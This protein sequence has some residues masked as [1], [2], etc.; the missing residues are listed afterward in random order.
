MKKRISSSAVG[1]SVRNPRWELHPEGGLLRDRLIRFAVWIGIAALCPLAQA[2]NAMPAEF[3][4]IAHRGASG[5]LP[6][7][8]QEAKALAHA[9][10]ADFLEQD[11]V[12]TKD[13]I[14]IVMHDI[15]LDTVTDVAEKFT[16]RARADGRYYAIDFELAEIRRL[17]ASERFDHKT[18]KA[19][20]PSRF[21]AHTGKF[22]IPTLEEEIQLIQ[23][24]NRS[25]GRTA[26]IY[27]ELKQ[28]GFH[29]REGKDLSRI[30]LEV[31]TRYGYRSKDDPI[32][33]QCFEADENVRIRTELGCQLRMIQLLGNEDWLQDGVADSEVARRLAEIAAYADGIGP[34]LST[35]FA[36]ERMGGDVTVRPIVRLARERGLQIHPW[37]YRADQLTRPFRNFEEMHLASLKAGFH[38]GFTDFPDQTLKIVRESR[39]AR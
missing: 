8:T 22:S 32:F 27:P 30:V 15:H 12:L 33:L 25:S 19:V 10:G 29:R 1:I 18:G 9:M 36:S 4:V 16:D 39:T 2:E 7:H 37:T 26:G 11:V 20:Y 3:V 24:L 5:Y 6:E 17:N 38:G 21:P 34:T 28:P 35:L 14:P 23:G 13:D 31:L